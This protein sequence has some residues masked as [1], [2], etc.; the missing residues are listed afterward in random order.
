MKTLKELAMPTLVLTVICVVVTAALALTYQ[1]TAPYIAAAAASAADSARI[2]LLPEADSFTQIT[3]ENVTGIEGL[4]EAYQAN[5]GAGY[6]FTSKAKGY[7]GDLFVMTGINSEGQV[8]KVKLME[9]A[10]TPGLGSRVGEDEY[11]SQYVEKDSKLEGVE[12]VSGATISS[13]AFKDAVSIAFQAYGA[14]AGVE[15]EVPAEPEVDPRTEIFPGEELTSIEIEGADEAYQAGS[16]GII[17]VVQ[18]E[19]YHPGMQVITGIGADGKIAGVGMGENEETKGLGTKVGE[20]EFTDK[21]K[22]L[23]ADE[24]NGVSAV[25]NATTSN[26]GF[27]RGVKK[28]LELVTQEML[29]ALATA[30]YTQVQPGA[31]TFEPFEAENA[32]EAV[33]TDLGIVVLTQAEGYGGQITAVVGIGNDGAITGVRFLS[34]H[35]ETKGIGTKA[36]DPEYLA[37]YVG[38]NSADG[39]DTVSGATVTTDA[40]KRAITKAL[41]IYE[42]TKG[43]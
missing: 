37:K 23:G 28:A 31:A 11:T 19:G 30:K 39:V 17:I 22:G 10:E 43:A 36:L 13:V 16:S 7:G 9:N 25:T 38:K 26:D 1:F 4:V 12:A 34:D 3:D 41:A 2:E 40:V 21:F 33:R 15:V 5:N 8:T 24:V 42:A 14:A 35:S 32:L 27:K 18:V 6:V 20:P 29:D